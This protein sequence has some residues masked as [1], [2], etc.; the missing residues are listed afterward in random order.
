ML[1]YLDL[2]LCHR[3]N[4][5][6]SDGRVITANAAQSN[7]NNTVD[8]NKMLV[9]IT[10][11][12]TVKAQLIQSP[13]DIASSHSA[14][15][16][17][18]VQYR[19][20]LIL[21]LAPSQGLEWYPRMNDIGPRR[22]TGFGLNVRSVTLSLCNITTQR[23]PQRQYSKNRIEERPTTGHADNWFISFNIWLAVTY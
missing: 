15:C 8:C 17:P 18:A 23:Q 14:K 10:K 2:L 11:K 20:L 16:H 19:C 3:R 1:S 22:V 13:T 5:M 9:G 12:F 21:N 4:G 7:Y 6:P